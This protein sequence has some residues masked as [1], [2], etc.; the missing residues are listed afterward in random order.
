MLVENRRRAAWQQ[1]R[2]Q[3]AAKEVG[4]AAIYLREGGAGPSFPARAVSVERPSTY[5][6]GEPAPVSWHGRCLFAY[7]QVVLQYA[8][9]HAI[10]FPHKSGKT[11][12]WSPL[13]FGDTYAA[14]DAD[15]RALA[16]SKSAP[17][18]DWSVSNHARAGGSTNQRQASAASSSMPD[19]V[20]R[21]AARASD[22]RPQSCASSRAAPRASARS[23][24]FGLVQTSWQQSEARRSAG[25][26][27][28]MRARPLTSPIRT[29]SSF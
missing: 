1:E 6:R 10:P 17:A 9:S 14:S 27:A 29:S 13:K 20:A 11:V 26:W 19:G 4:W 18:F 16:L 24:G 21:S 15:M 12:S 22:P 28:R 2:L 3:A 7:A 23:L 5:E 25:S 8:F